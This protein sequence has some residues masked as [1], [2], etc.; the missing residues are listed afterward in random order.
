[1]RMTSSIDQILIHHANAYPL[2]LP[3]DAVKLLYQSEF[4]P[5]HL[6]SDPVSS[7][8]RL[9]EEYSSVPHSPSSP[10]SEDIGNGLVRIHLSAIDPASLSLEQL[11][12]CFVRS[13]EQHTG[14]RDSFLQKLNTLRSLTN[15]AVFS[16]SPVELEEYL[17]SYI[18]SGFPAVSHSPR[19]R[20][21]YQPAYRVVRRSCLPAYPIMADA[22]RSHPIPDQRPLLVAIDGRCASGKTTLALQL[23]SNM[24]CSVVHM[25]DF[26]LRPE[27][28]T[29]QRYET[30]GENVDH[31]RFLDEVLLPL[32]QGKAVEYRPFNCST[33]QLAAPVSFAPTPIVVVEGSFSCHPN[34]WPYYDL[35]CFLTLSPEKQMQRIVAREGAEYAEVFRTKWIPLEEAYF[36]TYHLTS[37]CDF[38]F[39]Y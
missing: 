11:N 14:C 1:M 8:Q 30:P 28:R 25:D 35:R 4:G 17:T 15:R 9:R 19:Y 13:A 26:F 38:L 37:E 39:E 12:D 10:L 22:L 23:Q 20:N 33:Q 29:K 18:A 21:A 16:F 2:M 5:G 34:L 7:L 31:E 27:Q 36:S 3:Q 32:Y 6:V 24:G